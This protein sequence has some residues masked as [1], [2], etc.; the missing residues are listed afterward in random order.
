M[1]YIDF[2]GISPLLLLVALNTFRLISSHFFNYLIHFYTP[3]YFFPIY[4]VD[5]LPN[6]G[7]FLA[8]EVGLI[9]EYISFLLISPKK[10]AQNY[11]KYVVA[12]H[13]SK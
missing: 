5:V 11:F 9:S 10:G 6:L 7:S 8:H 3:F 4:S 2:F 1:I 13:L 12:I